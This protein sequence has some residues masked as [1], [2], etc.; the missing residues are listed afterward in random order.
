MKNERTGITTE[1]LYETD[2]YIKSFQATVLSAEKKEDGKLYLELDRT[3]FFPEGG[4]QSGD[5]GLMEG[6]QVEDTQKIDGRVYHIID[7]NKAGDDKEA[8]ERIEKNSES[9]RDEK[10]WESVFKEGN[11]VS[12]EVDFALRFRRM[13]NHIAEHLFCGI[14]NKRFG[15]DN[16]GFHLSDVVTFDLDGPLTDV[17]I[18]SIEDECNKAVWEN[19]PVTVIFPTPEEAETMPFR[20]KLEL[21]E[22]IRLVKIEGYDLCAC[23][24]P[25][26]HSTGEIGIVKVLDSMPHRG[27]TRITLIAGEDAWADYRC[28]DGQ[29]RELMK[30]FSAK[31]ELVSEM[32]EEYAKK[33]NEMHLENT[34]LRK[35]ITRLYAENLLGRID[36]LKRSGELPGRICFFM[37]DADE[38][39]VRNVINICVKEYDGIIAGFRGN[40]AEG[41]RYVRGRREDPAAG[42]KL[43]SGKEAGPAEDASTA[44]V[45]LRTF[46]KEMKE[47]FGGSGGGSEI[48][49]QGSAP[50][51]ESVIREF[52]GNP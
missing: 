47:A 40:D 5:R 51:K 26:L 9:I 44:P 37:K 27:G 10:D 23:C 34:E 43:K 52:F 41:Y 11:T 19:A 28:L 35:E 13:Q 50:A 15:Y 12:G 8:A 6:F 24:A 46:A 20:S 30:L 1:L 18:R 36:A 49:I 2:A 7:L 29:M 25:A 3:A 16:V 39:Q 17:E 48:M 42:S 33:T 31:R 38:V 4:G 32:A 14:A 45:S 21:S 22:G